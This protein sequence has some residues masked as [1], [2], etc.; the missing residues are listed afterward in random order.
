SPAEHDAAMALVSHAPQLVASALAAQLAG[1]AP[2]TLLLAGP[3]VEDT[4]RLAESEPR[5]WAQIAAGN[6][7][8]VAEIL[9]LIAGDLR[10]VADALRADAA[11]AAV[12]GLVER[13]REGRAR[14][15]GKHGSA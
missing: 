8:P 7:G 15:P 5:L 2:E 12:A 14:L 9:E 11:G 13:G 1:A 6:A 4:T 10:R 3:G